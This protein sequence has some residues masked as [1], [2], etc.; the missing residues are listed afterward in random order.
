VFLVG[1]ITYNY[2]QVSSYTFS[3]TTGTYT[4]ITTGTQLVTTV[5]AT[6]YDSDGGNF[7]LVVELV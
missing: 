4:S 7:T 5:G 3:E 6:S 1:I 2:S